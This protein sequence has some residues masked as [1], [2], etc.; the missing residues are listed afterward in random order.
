MTLERLQVIIEAQTRAYYEEL[1]KV[2]QQTKKATSAVE[3]QTEKI[4]SAFGKI[5][6]AV[7][8]A[9]SVT[10]LISFGKSCIE[11][12][13]DLAE[14]QNVVDVT[15]GAMSETINHFARD[16]LE[17]FGLSETSAKK[18]TS[19]LGAMLKS[20][21]IAT[22]QAAEMSMEMAGLA[23]DMAS[24][25]NLE[26][27]VAFEKIRSG[28]SGETEPLKQL[29]I[30][31]SVANLEAY[32]LSQGMTKAYSAMS[33][34]EQAILRYNYLLSVTADAQGDFA[35]T[36]DGWANQVRILTERFN[37]LKAAIGQ[38]LIAVLTPVI[39]VL[40]QLLAKILTVTDAFSNFIAK[41]TGKNTKTTTSVNEMGGALDSATDSAG[42]LSG[43]TDKAG[44]SAKKAEEAF[45]GLA[46]FDEI[47]SL[48]KA[49]EDSGSDGSGGGGGG[50]ASGGA[51][52]ESIVDAANEADATLN[53]VL[54]KIWNRMKELAEL[55]KKGFKAGL[56]D[57][58]LEPLKQAIEGIKKS[59]KEI[60][61]D[62][63]VLQ[64]ANNFLNTW[65]YSLGQ[66]AGA[67]ASIGITIA[68]NLL[69]G[70]N[71]YLDQNK[72]RI[73]QH[74]VSMF[75]I[76][77]E[78]VKMQGDFAQAAANIFSVFGGENGQQV[79]ANIIGIFANAAMGAAE[80]GAKLYRDITDIITRPFI[81]NQD[82][83]KTALDGTLGV[84]SGFLGNIKQVVD[85]TFSKANEVYDQHVA[86]MF[87]SLAAG[88]SS[89]T[90][91][92]LDAYNSYILPVLEGL[93]AKV[94]PLIDE[95]IQPA[96]NKGLELIGKIA[97]AIKDI[98]EQTLQ[99]FIEWFIATVAPY[100]A[101]A[102]DTVGSV[103]LT[104]A[105]V[106]ADVIG[107]IFDALG[108]LIDFIAGV[109][110]GDWQRAWEGIKT[111]F[112]AIWDAIKNI[113]SAVWSAIKAIISTALGVISSVI[114]AVLNTI[115]TIFST[116]WEAIKT[117]INTVWNA[118]KS[119]ISTT[120][121]T[122]STIISTVLNAIKTTFSTIF[123]SIKNTV[124]TIFNAIKTFITT[125]INTISTTLSTVLNIIKTTFS[126]ILENI[127]N[128]VTTVFN[129]IKAFI[130]TTINT[131]STTLSTVL[132]AI[133][134]TFSTILESIK[135][136]VTTVFNAIKST[137][138]TIINAVSTTISTV[139]NSIKTTFSTILNS[140][141][142]T[143][144]TIFNA[145][146][147]TITTIMG[148]IQSG[149][150]T[151][152]SSIKTTWS[153]MWESMKTTVINIFNG[154]WSSIKG[155]IN[156]II[157]GIEKMAN[158]VINGINGMIR[159]LNNLS[160]DVPD[161]VPGIGG[162]TFGFNISTIGNISIPRL[163]KGGVV[164]QATIAMV[165][166][167]GQEAVVP[168]ENNTGWMDK[169]AARIGE[170]ISMNLRAIIGEMDGAEEWQTIHTTVLLD[171]KTLVEQT[172]KYRRR[173]GY[174][175]A[176]A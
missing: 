154:I 9:F 15:F 129:A 60:W 49:A 87:S 96:I 47:H 90:G 69:G 176:N 172:D 54:E 20:M 162:K 22:N 16:A 24:F 131:I 67:A 120:I 59:L 81:D 138:T 89:I 48:T 83:F 104:V 88:L 94:K 17:Q 84:L 99:P 165:G 6:K 13:S 134:T 150:S 164:D 23:A 101:A 3:K 125:T 18:Y 123:E 116:I 72:E 144:N 132:N 77:S 76:S 166:E 73:K 29:G 7:A 136:T 75:D 66:Q 2:Q 37:A 70:L 153:N 41:I 128:T 143:V 44:K 148:T 43:A 163:A 167:A 110:T 58:T 106:V 45:H 113:V 160:F 100:I 93:Q 127:K 147:S 74:I 34:Q 149:I 1:Q 158:G 32:A 98:W 36:S 46:S 85:D 21:G 118:I 135:N 112:S 130:T 64:A 139:L 114:S 28:I 168:L 78:I 145:I 108:G 35:R 50:G 53:P 12:G 71:K 111:F 57:V 151:A 140:I 26:T 80:I 119:I 169:V 95:H 79:T 102:L 40:N 62:P 173:K 126:T 157:G 4:K 92:L 86:P 175:M 82:K 161:W 91:K 105:G 133:K 109:F 141:K 55:F 174:Q 171:S 115:K 117:L 124:T 30:N 142:T 155:V 122:I 121:N 14:V 10:A 97:D 56:G 146:K 5:G 8:V 103:F 137:I 11:L 152:L 170:I 42:S 33:Q 156:S 19:T 25:Y 159:A 39:R 51:L 31:L 63:A 52:S 65:A 38:G 107:N 27:D 61:T 68:T